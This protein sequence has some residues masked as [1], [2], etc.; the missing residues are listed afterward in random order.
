[1]VLALVLLPALTGVMGGTVPSKSGNLWLAVGI[2]FGKVVLFIGLMLVAGVRFF[3]WLLSQVEKTGSRELFTLAVVALA[4][5]IA[6]G[7][8]NSLA[9]LLLWVRFSLE[10]S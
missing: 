6:F 4:L 10:W 2:T 1:M 5:G 8:A 9:F 3:P 7:S